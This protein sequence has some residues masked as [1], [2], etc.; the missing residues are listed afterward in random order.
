MPDLSPEV[1]AKAIQEASLAYLEAALDGS[2]EGAVV[3]A[4]VSVVLPAHQDALKAEN[5]RLR[6]EN[7]ESRFAESHLRDLNVAFDQKVEQLVAAEAR[8]E[9]LTAA[10]TELVDQAQGA[11]MLASAMGVHFGPLT[12]GVENARA[13]LAAGEEKS[14]G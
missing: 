13:A 9:V 12:V 2:W 1:R 5:E 11:L 4:V 6:E 10:L 8:V 3:D 14:G 7:R